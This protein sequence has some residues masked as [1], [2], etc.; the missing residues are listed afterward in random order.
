MT[1]AFVLMTALPPTYGH[2]DLIHFAANIPQVDQVVVLL[3]TQPSEPYSKERSVALQEAANRLPS[4]AKVQI[5]WQ[6]EE[7][8]QEATGPDD[9]AFWDDWVHN[10]H[11]FGFEDGDIIVAS[12][13]YGVRLAAEAKG[14][15][16]VYDRDR[17]VR[18]T[19][20]TAA[21][22]DVFGQWDK[23][24]PEFRKHL[25]TKVTIFGAEST[26][27]TTLTR[28]LQRAYAEGD[29]QTTT[30]F[31]WARPYLEMTDPEV[32][33]QGMWDIWFGQLALQKTAYDNALSPLVIQDTDL[34]TTIGF[35][36]DWDRSTAP[37]GIYRD[38]EHTKSDLY[39]IL[40]SNIPFEHD[41]LR[42]GGEE[43][44]T[45][46][47][48]WVDICE[49]YGLSYVV[50]D[51]DTLSERVSEAMDAIRPILRKVIDYKRRGSEY[52]H[53]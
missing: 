27:K 41:I 39:I 30:L 14:R 48:Y 51:A 42:Y 32:T 36:E 40:R 26:G 45:S 15:F 20:G 5:K 33:V 12:E 37:D 52:E 2:L 24:L 23:I 35:W 17:W 18:Y 49:T 53:D 4:G 11:R 1:Q 46:D 19:K 31:E 22:N 38:A 50:L 16:M 7:V 8:Q 25:Q 29:L 28:A 47:Q 13:E 34:Y 21:R 43:R 9:Q 3:N 44:Q 6:N 10:L